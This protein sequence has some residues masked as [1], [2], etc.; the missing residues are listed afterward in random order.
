MNELRS[1][2]LSY[3]EYSKRTELH[4]IIT[5]VNIFYPK[6]YVVQQVT[7]ISFFFYRNAYNGGGEASKKG[8]KMT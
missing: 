4:I 8:V 3:R 5:I 2:S 1:T 7:P 6:F